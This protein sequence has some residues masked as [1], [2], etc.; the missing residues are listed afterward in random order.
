M[1]NFKQRSNFKTCTDIRGQHRY[2][3]QYSIILGVREKKLTNFEGTV[4]IIYILY[5]NQYM[6]HMPINIQYN[7]HA[8]SHDVRIIIRIAVRSYYDVMVDSA[9]CTKIYSSCRN[10]NYFILQPIVQQILLR[11]NTRVWV[12]HYYFLFLPCSSRPLLVEMMT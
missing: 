2:G 3:L 11:Y 1:N 5:L 9:N 10:V 12:L 4:I 8:Y 7:I 6:G